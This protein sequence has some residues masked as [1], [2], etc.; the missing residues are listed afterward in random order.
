MPALLL[1][2]ASQSASQSASH[3][4]TQPAHLPSGHLHFPLPQTKWLGHTSPQAPQLLL[5]FRMLI[6]QP[7]VAS[8]SQLARPRGQPV[9]GPGAARR[10]T[11]WCH[12]LLL[13]ASTR[14][15]SS[16]N[17]RRVFACGCGCLKHQGAVWDG[18]CGGTEWK[19]ATLRRVSKCGAAERLTKLPGA[20]VEGRLKAGGA[21]GAVVHTLAGVALAAQ[22][23]ACSGAG[24]AA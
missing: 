1:P 13:W 8:L 15:A 17:G 23:L 2:P 4:A 16:P 6:S 11:V 5:S 18:L 10:H 20:L 3:P 14:A 24:H 21:G 12:W 9:R 22:A 19:A 7:L